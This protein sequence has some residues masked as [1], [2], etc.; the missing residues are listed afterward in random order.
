[1]EGNGMNADTLLIAA[2][3]SL[4]RKA[5]DARKNAGD[6]AENAR[7]T[8]ELTIATMEGMR[9]TIYQEVAA[10]LREAARATSA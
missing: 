9:S 7:S 1:M 3:D 8:T 2:A 6:L 4:E 10:S 5:A